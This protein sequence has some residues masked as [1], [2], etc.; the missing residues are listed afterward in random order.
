MAMFEMNKVYLCGNLTFDP[1]Y[2]QTTTGRA[3]SKLRMAIN[4]RWKNRETGEQNEDTLFIDVETWN[5][6]AEF[7]KNYLSK[8]RRIFVEG[9]LQEDSWEDKETGQRRS[10]IK[11]VA[12]R[13]QFADAKP[14]D[15]SGGQG[16]YGSD[17]AHS[18]VASQNQ[19]TPSAMQGE[20]KDDLPF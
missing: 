11:V 1:E 16:Q 17:P 19:A 3:V 6:T 14:K 7:C 2:K 5:Q 10:K 15:G 8:G 9:R 4:R 13:V 12:D 20:T 18:D